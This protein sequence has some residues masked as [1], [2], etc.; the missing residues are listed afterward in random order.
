MEW[1]NLF[2]YINKNPE[3]TAKTGKFNKNILIPSFS[4]PMHLQK[5]GNHAN[6]PKSFLFPVLNQWVGN[7]Y[8]H[9][10]KNSEKE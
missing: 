6:S 2:I 3:K 9:T 4:L 5:I 8:L 10:N 1:T 7:F